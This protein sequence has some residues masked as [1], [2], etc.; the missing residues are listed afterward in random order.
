MLCAIMKTSSRLAK[1]PMAAFFSADFSLLSKSQVVLPIILVLFKKVTKT[2]KLL[3]IK[4]RCYNLINTIN[5]KKYLKGIQAEADATCENSILER[6]H[7]VT[8]Q[9]EFQ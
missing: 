2:Y 7:N 4:K 3:T 5:V 8:D 6:D 9:M 1:L